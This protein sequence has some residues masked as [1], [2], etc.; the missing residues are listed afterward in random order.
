MDKIPRGASKDAK[1]SKRRPNRISRTHGAKRQILR[2][3]LAD[4]APGALGTK[5]QGRGTYLSHRITRRLSHRFASASPQPTQGRH[6]GAPPTRTATHLRLLTTPH[7]SNPPRPYN[8]PPPLPRTQPPQRD[9]PGRTQLGTPLELTTAPLSL[10]T[11]PTTASF[12]PSFSHAKQTPPQH[13]L[14]THPYHRSH[15]ILS[16]TPNPPS[17][18]PHHPSHFPPP[19]TPPPPHTSRPP[20]THPPCSYALPSA[21]FF[22][23]TPS[24][25]PPK[26][27]AI[28]L[29]PHT[30]NPPP[31][32]LLLL[33]LPTA[34]TP[35]PP[36]CTFPPTALQLLTASAPYRSTPPF[37]HNPFPPTTVHAHIHSTNGTP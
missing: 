33:S 9:V 17:P 28:L 2:P 35:L 7:P 4:A 34:Y 15:L 30:F 37:P 3:H 29:P 10:I 11:D 14:P 13:P 26:T 12:P 23:F 25:L 22:Y 1:M 6:G 24:V 27:H 5:L 21:S 36:H 32:I 19:R 8:G 18:F 16:P 31:Q 20:S